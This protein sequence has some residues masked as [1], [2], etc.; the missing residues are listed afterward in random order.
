MSGFANWA[1]SCW[2][3]SSELHP[4][5]E[6]DIDSGFAGRLRRF[7]LLGGLRFGR[8]LR[9]RDDGR[10]RFDGGKG[11]ER[12]GDDLGEV[13]DLRVG[14]LMNAGEIAALDEQRA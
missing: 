7:D 13:G 5:L 2:T 4:L 3:V 11:G 10:M 1:F 12:V 6:R 9:L 14:E 8:G